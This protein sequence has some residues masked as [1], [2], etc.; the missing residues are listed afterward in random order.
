MSSTTGSTLW[1]LYFKNTLCNLFELGIII[2]LFYCF[3]YQKFI[4]F[5][6]NNI[7][8]KEPN[9]QVCKRIRLKMYATT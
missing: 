6:K 2:S 8:H 9:K 1:L 5:K 4:I 7:K 3:I